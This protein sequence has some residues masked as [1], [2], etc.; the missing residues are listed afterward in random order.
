MSRLTHAE[1]HPLLY[2]SN[3]FDVS[4]RSAL[5]ALTTTLPPLIF[6][7]ITSLILDWDTLQDFSFQLAKPSFV[8]LLASLTTLS[9]AN[10]RTRVLQSQSAFLW[11]GVKAHERS[12]CTAGLLIVERAPRLRLVAERRWVRHL[13][14][15]SRELMRRNLLRAEAEGAV[16]A[17]PGL[18]VAPPP[19]PSPADGAIAAS[20][21]GAS[22]GGPS[23]GVEAGTLKKPE[24][25]ATTR[26]KWRF[27]ASESQ[28][29][30]DET[31]VDLQAEVAALTGKGTG[32]D[33]EGP[34]QMA[35][36]LI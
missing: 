23:G 12:I 7:Q 13:G 22:S 17:I 8:A 5:Y 9:L 33:A 32:A 26:I 14:G 24:E 21:G 2:S 34:R 30:E 28:M 29:W 36:D 6:T 20:A 18:G 16:H 31:V 3:A 19:P 27:L 11:R 35:L 10:W 1:A 15:R 4:A 25:Q